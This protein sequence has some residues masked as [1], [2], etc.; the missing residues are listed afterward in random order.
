MRER[1][2]IAMVFAAG[3]GTRM[4]PVTDTL[5][6]P[7][8]QVGRRTL[9]DHMLDR[10]AEA[11]VARAIVN[12]H[13]RADQIEAHLQDRNNPAVTISDE[14]AKLL[15]QGGGIRKVLPLI[16]DRPF[17]IANTDAIWTDERENVVAALADAWDPARSDVLLLAAPRVGAIGVD[18]PGD[19]HLRDDGQ[20]IRRKPDE[21]SDYVYAGVGIMKPSL[22]ASHTDDVFRL[23][24]LFFE[25]AARGRLHGHVLRGRWLHVG[26]PAA[27]AEAE[28]ALRAK[29]S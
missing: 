24:P 17:F 26:T 28:D 21:E 19:F 10:F 27:I 2:D 6:K 8:V 12:V 13:Y 22:F 25:A 1:P 7:L 4:R 9:L 16:G 18:W 11:G 29:T 15:D 20:L 23:A 3:L 14:R 5:P